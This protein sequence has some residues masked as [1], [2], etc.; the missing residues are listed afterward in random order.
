[1]R[2]LE[3]RCTLPYLQLSTVQYITTLLY[4]DT[5]QYSKVQYCRSMSGRGGRCLWVSAGEAGRYLGS[6]SLRARRHI[7]LHTVSWYR[8]NSRHTITKCEFI[9][10]YVTRSK[11]E[12][13]ETWTHLYFIRKKTYPEKENCVS[14]SLVLTL[15]YAP[16]PNKYFYY[17]KGNWTRLTSTLKWQDPNSLP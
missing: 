15:L 2:I 7:I 11:E 3:A 16:R 8:S 4:L 12:N 13:Q 5:A 9:F 1:M 10:Q 14:H 6:P 17:K